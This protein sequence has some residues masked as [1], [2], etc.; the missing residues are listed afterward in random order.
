MQEFPLKLEKNTLNNFIRKLDKTEGSR[1]GS[2]ERSAHDLLEIDKP[3]PDEQG[4]WPVAGQNFAGH[5]RY[6]RTYWTLF[7]IRQQY[8]ICVK[9]FFNMSYK[10]VSYFN[11][12]ICFCFLKTI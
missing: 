6:G 7:S 12:S 8:R 9:R 1:P 11:V 5:S 4:D 3:R 10:V 2:S